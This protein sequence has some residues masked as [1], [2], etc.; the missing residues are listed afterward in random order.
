MTSFFKNYFLILASAILLFSCSND[1]G[2]NEDDIISEKFNVGI[3]VSLDK[4]IDVSPMDLN[5][6]TTKSSEV[7]N[8]MDAQ[9]D[10]IEALFFNTQTGKMTK[11]ESERVPALSQLNPNFGKINVTLE[12]GSYRGI[13][14]LHQWASNNIWVPYSAF[15]YDSNP[16]YESTMMS[17]GTFPLSDIQYAKIEFDVNSDLTLN[18]KTIRIAARISILRTTDLPSNVTDVTFV[19]KNFRLYYNPSTEQYSEPSSGLTFFNSRD[20]DLIT[21]AVY[22]T[23]SNN[24]IAVDVYV[25]YVDKGKTLVKTITGVDLPAGKKLTMNVD[26]LFKDMDGEI[27]IEIDPTPWENVELPL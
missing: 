8:P 16:S 25:H 9:Y 10:R 6:I 15:K 13:I 5:E 7:I 1:N 12:K 3:N 2:I 18:V 20:S 17:L 14:A 24:K 19:V 23:D 11:F 4:V 27:N 26:E 21:K 22:P